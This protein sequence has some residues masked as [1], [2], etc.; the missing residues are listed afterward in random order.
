MFMKHTSTILFILCSLLMSC[1]SAE[2]IKLNSAIEL[3][4]E[5]AEELLKVLQHYKDDSDTLKY[6][7]AVFLIENMPYHHG[8]YNDS[9]SKIETAQKEFI[10]NGFVRPEIMNEMRE[11][12]QFIPKQ[13]IHC[14]TAEYLIHNIDQAFNVWRKR[15]WGK[16]Y[17]FTDFCEYLLPYRTDNEPLEEW[18]EKYV[19]RYSFLLDSVYTGSD[20]VEA[21][22]VVCLFLREE[23]FHHTHIFNEIPA[24]ASPSFLLNYRTGGCTEESNLTIHVL[25]SLG[26][27]VQKDLYTYSP[28]TYS[29][30]GWCVVLDTNKQNIPFCYTDYLPVRGKMQADERKKCK[31]YR[32]TY[33]IQDDILSY[34]ADK[35]MPRALKN[36]FLKD[37]SS[38][39][40]QTTLRLP[41]KDVRKRYYLG[42]FNKER[43]TPIFVGQIEKDSVSFGTVE[44]RNIYLL[45]SGTNEKLEIESDPFV[46]ID[47]RINYLKANTDK[48]NKETLYRKFPLFDWNQ[49]RMYRIIEAK[50]YGGDHLNNVN[51]KLYEVCDTPYVCY[52]TYPLDSVLEKHRYLKYVARKDVLLELAELHFFNGTKEVMPQHIIAG[53]AYNKEDPEMQLKNCFDNDPL[54]Y[55]LSKNKGDSI[56]F[57][58]GRKVAV[59]HAVCVPRNDDNFI[60]IGDEYELFYFDKSQGWVS[61]FR[62]VADKVVM[63]CEVPDNALLMLRDRTRGK[64]EQVF[65]FNNHKQTYICNI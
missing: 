12:L 44:D 27:P 5:N 49:E 64:E 50:F 18:R 65:L 11:N 41:I 43:I 25:R 63:E 10:A 6:A 24:C 60:R 48:M 7:A 13:D 20:V 14:I 58:F 26:I 52:N 16:H 62:Q 21:T 33:Q 34:K 3:A 53:E 9:I 31:V 47:N 22:N 57:D 17:S 35:T 28:E 61:L 42:T 55:F 19:S 4:G 51:E 2:T 15:P 32:N 39:Y 40:F 46:F 23:G 38:E 56:I 1:T 54:S 45:L 59:T 29:S 37:V 8:L 30:H 36:I